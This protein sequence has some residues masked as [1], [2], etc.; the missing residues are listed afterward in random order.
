MTPAVANGQTVL[1]GGWG[2]SPAASI[3]SRQRIWDMTEAQV[4]PRGVYLRW[5]HNQ[6]QVILPPLPA[7]SLTLSFQGPFLGRKS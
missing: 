1:R 2:Q 4:G 5:G 7:T 6:T 3:S